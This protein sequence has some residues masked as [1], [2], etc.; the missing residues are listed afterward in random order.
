LFHTCNSVVPVA[1]FAT[2]HGSISLLVD[3]LASL[4]PDLG[5]NAQR[6]PVGGERIRVDHLQTARAFRARSDAAE[7]FRVA[8]IR[9]CQ[10]CAVQHDEHELMSPSA[11]R[12]RFPE[13]LADLL[14]R[15]ARAL[16][17][18]VGGL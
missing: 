9:E 15:Y 14:C 6:H 4:P 7:R 11:P 3:A 8:A 18:V 16:D 17:E 13:R 1:T 12:C 5:G 2:A 10:T